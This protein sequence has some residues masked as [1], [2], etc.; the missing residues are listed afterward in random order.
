MNEGRSYQRPVMQGRTSYPSEPLI[1]YGCGQPGHIKR[2]CPSNRPGLLGP[3]PVWVNRGSKSLPGDADVYIVIKLF[4][5]E[6]PCLVDSGSDTTIVPKNLTDRFKGLDVKPS[7]R[8]VWAANNTP[9]RVYGET[10]LPFVLEKRCV[11][12]PAL[13]SEDVDEIMVGNDWLDKHACQLNF[14][15]KKLIVDG[16]ETVTLIRRGHAGRLTI[17]R[18]HG[19]QRLRAVFSSSTAE[20]R[21]QASAGEPMDILQQ[22]DPDIG[23]ILR[24]RCRQTNQPSF[25]EVST[26][27]KTAKVLWRQL[28][29][30][31]VRRNVLY[32]RAETRKGR[33]PTLQLVVPAV[34]RT[35][36]IAFCHQGMLGRHRAFRTTLHQVRR[37][38]FWMGWRRDVLQ[39]CR[40]CQSCRRYFQEASR[41]TDN[42]SR[43]WLTNDRKGESKDHGWSTDGDVVS[44]TVDP[45]NAG[46]RADDGGDEVMHVNNSCLL[47]TSPSPRD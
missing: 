45:R 44:G 9:I 35:E 3:P 1:C 30:L 12:T 4:G 25:E 41:N 6:F 13:I 36:F 31:V 40:Q 16:Q 7:D 37:K 11:W 34:K 29:C 10:E 47:Y 28:H 23:P 17:D 43:S 15:T 14:K 24:L 27:S 19:R 46:E 2:N 20:R 39:Y 26:Q 42:P 38:G 8:S 5:Q 18:E 33:P 32:R 22:E 21:E